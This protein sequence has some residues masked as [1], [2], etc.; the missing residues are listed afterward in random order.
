MRFCIGIG[1]FHAL[2]IA[3]QAARAALRLIRKRTQI[4]HIRIMIIGRDDEVHV[5]AIFLLKLF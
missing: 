4:L 1:F 5:M 2:L 3:K